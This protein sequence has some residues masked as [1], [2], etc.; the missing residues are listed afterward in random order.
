MYE[1][2]LL[3]Y[4]ST[5]NK[6]LTNKNNL[7]L[8]ETV[9]LGQARCQLVITTRRRLA[10]ISVPGNHTGEVRIVK[11]VKLSI[12]RPRIETRCIRE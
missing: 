2:D 10:Q 8:V 1:L 6:F 5:I 3:M 11:I 7:L 9:D 12:F 4:I